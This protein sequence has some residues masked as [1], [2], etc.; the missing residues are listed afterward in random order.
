[1]AGKIDQSRAYAERAIKLDPDYPL[2]YYNLACADAE[3]GKA[4]DARA[5]AGDQFEDDRIQ[6]VDA[7]QTPARG[8]DDAAKPMTSSGSPR[9]RPILGPSR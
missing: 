5:C 8:S 9:G 4:A 6:A 2:Y 1:M 3:Q 7:A